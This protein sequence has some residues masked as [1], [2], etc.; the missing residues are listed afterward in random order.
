EF[1]PTV[2]NGRPDPFACFLDFG[3]GQADQRE[4]GQTVGQMD[5]HTD[6]PGLKPQQRAAV[7]QRQAHDFSLIWCVSGLRRSVFRSSEACTWLV[8]TLLVWWRTGAPNQKA[9]HTDG[10]NP[11]QIWGT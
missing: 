10:S 1:K 9:W 3:I 4:A 5:L 2:G 11:P 6:R 7:H 8:R